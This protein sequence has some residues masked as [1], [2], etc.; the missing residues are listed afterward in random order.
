MSI[1][2]SHWT[3][4][5]GLF[6]VTSNLP[7]RDWQVQKQRQ[8]PELVLI[9]K[10]FHNQ[11]VKILGTAI[12]PTMSRNPLSAREL[13]CLELFASGYEVKQIAAIVNSSQTTVRNDLRSVTVKLGCI[14]VSHAVTKALAYGLIKVFRLQLGDYGLFETF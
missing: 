14:N 8:L 11:V 1:P 13:Q 4:A 3:G 6:T 2:V 9:A 10:H 5:R 12:P 7:D